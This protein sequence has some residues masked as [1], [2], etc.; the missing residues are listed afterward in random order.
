MK[1]YEIYP[2]VNLICGDNEMSAQTY[3]QNFGKRN[4]AP[5]V[6][7]LVKGNGRNILVDSGGSEAK[8]AS[9]QHHPCEQSPEM[10]PEN[11]VRGAGVEPGDID[12][13]VSTHL[14]WDHC[15]NQEKFPNA[16]IY[17]QKREAEFAI[18]PYPTHWRFYE[19]PKLGLEM[20]WL[21]HLNRITF[22]DGDFTL[23][24][25]VEVYLMPGHAPGMQNVAVQTTNGVYLIASDNIP[26]YL[27]WEG[28]DI[29]KH[30][31]SAIHCNLNDYYATFEKMEKVCDHVLPSHDMKLLDFKVFPPKK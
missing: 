9:A 24:E 19:H 6:I 8:I 15:Y 16:A 10:L 3:L 22:V 4:P 12:T 5:V 14:H 2:L 25:G 30:I 17:V 28:A 23:C 21:R 29:H 18:N 11:L 20:P 7:W 13:S 27:N 26:L 1:T 31:P